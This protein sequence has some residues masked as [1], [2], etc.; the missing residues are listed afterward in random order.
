MSKQIE[1]DDKVEMVG[2]VLQNNTGLFLV[3]ID[4]TEQVITCQ[5]SGKI[6]QNKINIV[7]GDK[8]RVE[9]SPY[10]LTK[11]RISRRL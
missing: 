3:K 8:V 11:G 5:P 4:G 10:D 2:T 7:A 9:L 6:R 1:R